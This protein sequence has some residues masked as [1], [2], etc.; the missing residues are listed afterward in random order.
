MTNELSRLRLAVQKSGRL[1]E[2]CFALLKQ[3][4]IKFRLSSSKL[5]CHCQNFPL[6]LLLVRDD[7][8][9][10]LVM[11]GACDLGIVGR[12][13]L[14]EYSLAHQALTCQYLKVLP[15]G[16]CVLK[17]AVPQ[18]F[19]YQSVVSLS[20]LR[21]A[22][23]YPHL[24]QSYL[25]QNDIE[26]TV[27]ELSGSVEIAPRLGLADAICDLVS[28]GATLEANGLKAV[29]T[30]FE[31][32]ARLIGRPDLQVDRSVALQ[33][34][35]NRMAGVLQA[36]ES[37]YV[38]LHAPKDKLQQIVDLLPGAEHPTV[39]PLQGHQQ[40]VAVHAVCYES[41]FWE[42]MEQ[43]KAAGASA[44]LVLPIEKMMV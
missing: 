10:S 14:Q 31:S 19:V 7:D 30:V 41:V 5:L 21:I 29:A 32:E 25:S 18:S 26:A 24:L 15:F 28:T 23:S 39:V 1:S 22:T 13:V 36:K 2:D 16:G 9:P 42:T 33:S 11:Q 37:K 40:H 44:V 34:L 6:D 4:G 43:L 17:I 12:N 27:I 8:I 20:G 38:M 3:C 35:F